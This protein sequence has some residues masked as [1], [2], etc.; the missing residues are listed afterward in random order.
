MLIF[1]LKILKGSV[2]RKCRFMVFGI[3][4]FVKNRENSTERALNIS[5][6]MANVKKAIKHMTS[7]LWALSF[8]LILETLRSP[9]KLH[10]L[11]RPPQKNKTK[12]ISISCS[13]FVYSQY[14]AASTYLVQLVKILKKRHCCKSPWW[15]SGLAY[16]AVTKIFRI[17]LLS[18]ALYKRISAERACY[19]LP[20]DL[21]NVLVKIYIP[22]AS[23]LKQI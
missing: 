2:F 18:H 21:D 6:S 22:F 5:M 4:S 14:L 16:V 10:F 3:T 20:T 8:T 12:H 11:P 15:S 13:S 19:P 9:R 23:D 17:W 1:C 7:F